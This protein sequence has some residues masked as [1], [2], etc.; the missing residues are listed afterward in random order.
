MMRLASLGSRAPYQSHAPRGY[1]ADERGD[2]HHGL[3]RKPHSSY[4]GGPKV[5]HQPGVHQAH[6][7]IEE[8]LHHRGD[9]Q[10]QDPALDASGFS[11]RDIN[12]RSDEL[13]LLSRLF[14]EW[15]QIEGKRWHRRL[16]MYRRQGSNY[17]RNPNGLS[18]R[19]EPMAIVPLCGLR[20]Y[21]LFQNW[22]GL[23]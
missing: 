5:P 12:R 22:V 1:R 4:R 14:G 21:K 9:G 19:V 15:H 11:T 20:Y 10:L 16:A 17:S 8:L 3:V 7:H 6:G 2:Q 18:K 23:W 13:I